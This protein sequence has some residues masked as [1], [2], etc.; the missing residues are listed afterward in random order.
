MAENL[1][2]YSGHRA[3]LRQRLLDNGSE[4]LLDHELLEY[5]LM[6]AIPRRD[7][8][9]LAKKLIARF[10]SYAS[11][12]AASPADL[13]A[14]GELSEAVVGAIKIAHASS[15]RLLK[16]GVENRPI[17]SS[18]QALLDYLHADLA[19]RPTE[20]VRLL[21]LNARNVLIRDEIIAKGSVDQAAI[22]TREV[23]RFALDYHASSMILVHNHPSGDP[24]P[25][26]A[27]IQM[28]KAIVQAGRLLGINLHDHIIIGQS[29]HASFKALGLL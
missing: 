12:I 15:L 29:G 9:P 11:V 26:R 3:R 19:F 22:H 24:Q 1:V 10:G 20:A 16:S 13:M 14:E 21:L 2:Q 17:L 18:W 8:K 7:T 6:L 5:L 28:T 25:S 23:I 4:A 27:D